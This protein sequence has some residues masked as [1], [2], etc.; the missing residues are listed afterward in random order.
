MADIKR[1]RQLPALFEDWNKGVY[2]ATKQQGK[3]TYRKIDGREK[4]LRTIKKEKRR[5]N[6]ER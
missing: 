1:M 2:S 5:K 3:R 6:G 4:K